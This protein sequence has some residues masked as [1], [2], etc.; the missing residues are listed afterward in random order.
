MARETM[1]AINIAR[2]EAAIGPL[3]F[4][5]F[6][7]IFIILP[8]DRE[9]FVAAI[10]PLRDHLQ[11]R[12]PTLGAGHANIPGQ[13]SLRTKNKQEARCLLNAMN[14]A[15]R[16]PTVKPSAILF[17]LPHDMSEQSLE[18][19]RHQRGWESNVAE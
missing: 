2:A 10:N 8:K 14:E 15:H 4:R 17:G 9:M 11:T 5:I 12:F 7:K 6:L 1:Q 13:S 18:K 3:F 16:Q 19:V